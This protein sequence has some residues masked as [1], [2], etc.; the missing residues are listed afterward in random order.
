MRKGDISH[1]QSQ[2]DDNAINSSVSEPSVIMPTGV[3]L[4][5]LANELEDYQFD[6][7]KNDIARINGQFIYEAKTR[8]TTINEIAEENRRLTA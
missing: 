5:D 1:T 7:L 6:L 8:T 3:P 2:Q 4:R